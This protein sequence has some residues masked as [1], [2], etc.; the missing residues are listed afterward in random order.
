MTSAR[1]EPFTIHIEDSQLDD[2]RARLAATRWPDEPEGNDGWDWGAKLAYMRRLVEYWRDG[3]DWRAHEARLNRF[4]QYRASI[5]GENGEEHRIHFVLERG[6][7]S[8]PKPLIMTHGWPSTFVEFLETIERLAHPERFGGDAEDAFD[9]VVPSCPG[10]GFSSKP[11]TP[12]GA[13]ATAYLWDRLMR[14]ILGYPRYIAHGGDFGGFVT[15]Q[16]GLHYENSLY[17]IHLTMLP[18]VFRLEYEDQ[19]PLTQ[20]ESAYVDARRRSGLR[21]GR[22]YSEIQRTRPMALAYAVTD[23]PAGLAAWVT[24][25]FFSWSD[26]ER[27][28]PDAGFEARVPLDQLLT[29]LSVYW[30]TGTI[31]TANYIYK[32]GELERSALLQPGK[33]VRVPTGYADYPPEPDFHGPRVPRSWAERAHSNIV[34]WSE[35]PR[36]GHFAALAEPELFVADLQAFTSKLRFA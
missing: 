22:G 23:S 13:K 2:L 1:P 8:N 17:G 24:D 7:G 14:D 30:F 26:F 4:S 33:K 3:H 20:E 16:L 15:G 18:L 32:A 25:K 5:P 10:F 21:G 11:R 12:I 28:D 27:K 36:G 29:M 19:P 31:G 34:H 9:V 6:S 35:L